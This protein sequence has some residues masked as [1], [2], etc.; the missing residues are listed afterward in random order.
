M[1]RNVQEKGRGIAAT[2]LAAAICLTAWQGFAAAN[3]PWLKGVTDKDPLT[4]RCGEKIVFTL[5]LERAETLPS[6]LDIVWTRTGDDGRQEILRDSNGKVWAP[7]GVQ[8]RNERAGGFVG[9]VFFDGG[10]GVDVDAIRQGV[11]EPADY[12]AFWARHKAT[13]AAI[14]MTDVKCTELPSRNPK[15]KIF[16]VSVPCAGPK[17]ATGYLLVPTA[18]GKYPAEITFH[19]YGASWSARATQA[20][21]GTHAKTNRLVLALSA[22]GFE[23][24]RE[25]AYYQAERKKV[26]SNG[27][28]HAFD[29]VQN[30]DPEKAYFCGMTYRVMRGLEYLKSRPE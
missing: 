4:Y 25:P 22:H 8:V 30:A 12:D 15:V 16:I 27:H 23:L 17:P 13:L 1:K 28:G 2:G 14:Q 29:P 18:A 3:T 9:A 24:N 21:D 7:E 5:T 10:A 11:A 20:P 26:M 6:G 19:G